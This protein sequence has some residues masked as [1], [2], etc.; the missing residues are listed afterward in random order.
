MNESD[1][2]SMSIIELQNLI[3]DIKQGLNEKPLYKRRNYLREQL[4][5]IENL[6]KERYDNL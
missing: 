3:I 1:Y 6:I 2:N 4:E 5:L